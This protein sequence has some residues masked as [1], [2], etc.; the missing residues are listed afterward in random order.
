MNQPVKTEKNYERL[1]KIRQLSDMLYDT[2]DEF[3]NPSEHLAGE[4]HCAVQR[5][6]IFK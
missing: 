6:V 4:N 3:C 5:G 2:D 1:W